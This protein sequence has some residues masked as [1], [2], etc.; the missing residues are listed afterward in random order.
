MEY[1]TIILCYIILQRCLKYNVQFNKT[2]TY[3]NGFWQ[4]KLRHIAYSIY[5]DF[6]IHN[7]NVGIIIYLPV[8]KFKVKRHIFI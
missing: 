3:Y 6:N 2:T 8:V 4:N 1:I 5:D 7:N